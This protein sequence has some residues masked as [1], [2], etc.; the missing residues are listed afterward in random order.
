[1]LGSGKAAG[2]HGC[3]LPWVRWPDCRA[4][5]RVGP[6]IG[7][8]VV[9]TLLALIWRGSCILPVAFMQLDLAEPLAGRPRAT[10][11]PST[12]CNRATSCS[13][14]AMVMAVLWPLAG[15]MAGG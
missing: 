1:M 3:C 7:R 2:S 14:L 6:A 12:I 13:E 15:T 10:S 11:G 5:L 4:G 8:C 9:P